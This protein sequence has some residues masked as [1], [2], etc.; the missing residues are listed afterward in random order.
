MTDKYCKE[1]IEARFN[2]DTEAYFR[3]RKGV[4][5]LQKTGVVDYS[6]LLRYLEKQ[7]KKL[8]DYLGCCTVSKPYEQHKDP[9]LVSHS[10]FFSFPKGSTDE[11]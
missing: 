2:M 8:G 1:R 6:E 10:F 7:P 11:C 9:T 3:F 4:V 5:T